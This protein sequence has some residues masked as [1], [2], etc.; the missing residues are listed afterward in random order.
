MGNT[1]PEAAELA[2][3]FERARNRARPGIG[4]L[5]AVRGIVRD[6][7]AYFPGWLELGRALQRS[8][9]PEGQGKDLLE[10]AGV[11]LESAVSVSDRNA[12]ALNELAF[13]RWVVAADA[14]TAKKLFEESLRAAALLVEDASVGLANI[15]IE[16]DAFAEAS[17]VVKR[18]LLQVP[19]SARLRVLLDQ[20]QRGV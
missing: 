12:R 16:E 8:E 14:G 4:E 11:A 3:R 5:D 7:P 10:E 18:G 6:C 1:H 13:Y 20:L 15:L 9:D 19:E 2:R 17:R